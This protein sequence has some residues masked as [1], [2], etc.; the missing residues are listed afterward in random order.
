M[1]LDGF[2]ARALTN[3]KWSKLQGHSFARTLLKFL[4]VRLEQHVDVIALA[5][6]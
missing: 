2:N 6:F 4:T 1:V 3:E 5:D